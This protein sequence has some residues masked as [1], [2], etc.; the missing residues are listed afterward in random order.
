MKW[1]A[2]L[3]ALTASMGFAG[4]AVATCL[5]IDRPYSGVVGFWE[6]TCGYGVTV[7]WTTGSGHEGLTWVGGYDR[8]TAGVGKE[9]GKV[10]W[11][12][13]RSGRPYQHTP[14]QTA[15]GWVCD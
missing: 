7:Q 1:L 5:T 15:S 14:R 9:V 12:E 8:V 2:I 13:C 11:R 3:I 6:N 4:N 10:R